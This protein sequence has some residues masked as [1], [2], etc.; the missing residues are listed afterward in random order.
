L[1][2][3]DGPVKATFRWARGDVKMSGKTM[4]TGDRM[5]LV[6]ASVNR[7]PARYPDP[8]R[9]DITRNPNPHVAFGH[10]IH[11]CLG[12]PLALVEGQEAFTA[13]AERF[14]H[15]HLASED[16][17]YHPTLVSRALSAL[18]AVNGCF[19]EE[20]FPQTARQPRCSAWVPV[21][22]RMAAH[23]VARTPQPLARSLPLPRRAGRSGRTRHGR[24]VRPGCPEDEA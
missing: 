7:D 20:E 13:L 19:P 14:R 5:V 4:R 23:V 12:A 21:A 6:L 18:H 22:V 15:M 24:R 17:E 1:L 9:V 10:G 2:R 8:N 3:Y 11:V 16:L